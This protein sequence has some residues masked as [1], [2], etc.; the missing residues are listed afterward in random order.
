[1]ILYHGSNV[2]ITEV[3]LGRSEVG[4][5]FGAGF[6]LTDSKEQAE[7]MGQRKAVCSAALQPYPHL[8]SMNPLPGP[9]V[10]LSRSSIHI[11]GSGPSL[12]SPTGPTVPE[13]RFTISTSFTVRSPMTTSVTKSDGCLPGS[14]PWMH[15]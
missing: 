3:D 9:P 12:S 15:S 7:R 13:S 1:M 10:L 4:K 11:P 2:R 8:S 5:D 6:Y 14:S